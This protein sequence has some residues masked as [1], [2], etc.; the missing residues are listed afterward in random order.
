MENTKKKCSLEEHNEIDAIIYCI[1]CQIYMCN[2]CENFHSKLFKNHQ[3]FTLEKDMKD[4]FIGY[5]F[6]KEH[7]QKLNFF[8]KTHNKLCCAFCI[9]KI[10]T[11]EVG[12][13][14][15]CEVFKIED[16][17]N[18]KKNKLKE[19]IKKLEELSKDLQESIDK[20]K[21]VFES[22]NESKE[23]IKNDIQK[24]FTK[25]RNELNKL[26]PKNFSN[27]DE[28]STLIEKMKYY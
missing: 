6:E 11:E 4:I 8:C 2:K 15:D 28:K 3:T 9:S 1:R 18:E 19:N 13:H 7:F 14:K 21:I 20:L 22:I 12:N 26:F 23:T 27:F 5:C 16:V 10:K 24:V 25:L 17:K